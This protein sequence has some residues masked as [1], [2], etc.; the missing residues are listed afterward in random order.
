MTYSIEVQFTIGTDIKQSAGGIVGSSDERV[1]IGEELD[2]VDV[3]FV[4]GKSLDRLPGTN[5]PELGERV[6][7][8]GNK[9]VLVGGIQA[10]AHDIAEMVGKLGDLLARLNV[11]F[12]AGHVTGRGEDAA[13]V[14]ES[15][16]REIAGVAG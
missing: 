9:G 10:D 5:I 4:A 13:V 15:T 8:T 11:P 7:G 14:N 2:G 6:A 1:A 3:G 16:A 12:H